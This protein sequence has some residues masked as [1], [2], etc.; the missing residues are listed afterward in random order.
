MER[1]VGER[2]Q[3]M[4]EFHNVSRTNGADSSESSSETHGYFMSVNAEGEGGQN[5]NIWV[6]GN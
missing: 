3:F 2:G 4:W 5:G 6:I 1:G